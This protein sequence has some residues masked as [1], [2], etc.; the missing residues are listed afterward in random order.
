MCMGK[1]ASHSGIPRE[2][3]QARLER[4]DLDRTI[5]L[6]QILIYL[7]L[8]SIIVLFFLGVYLVG[9]D[10]DD[11][12]RANA[13]A[14]LCF[15][16]MVL[17][18][19][20]FYLMYRNY[21]MKRVIEDRLRFENAYYT[22]SMGEEAPSSH[23][24]LYPPQ[25]S[26]PQG[27]YGYTE[28]PATPEVEAL[29]EIINNPNVPADLRREAEHKLSKA[30]HRIDSRYIPS[31][32]KQAVYERDQ[33]RCVICGSMKELEYDHIIPFSRGGANSVGNVQ[34]LCRTCNRQKHAKII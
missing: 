32:V 23:P 8:I 12:A 2:V 20:L 15:V 26:P 17:L 24:I 5:S 10:P 13:G 18:I 9:T 33:G 21:M 22:G 1:R 31:E 27:P 34:L 4:E 25:S 6:F 29:Y 16:D 14:S 3:K 7:I 19:P 30:T 28:V 11:G